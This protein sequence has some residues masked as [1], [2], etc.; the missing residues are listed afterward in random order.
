M[1]ASPEHGLAEAR[2]SE[3]SDTFRIDRRIGLEIIHGAAQAPCPGADR[4]PLV[5]GWLG[6]TRLEEHGSH[7]VGDAA[8][9]VR[10]DLAVVD[11]RDTEA[12]VEQF[13]ERKAPE[14]AAFTRRDLFVIA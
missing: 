7:T 9:E 2:Y 3:D 11:G 5:W 6:F 1:S 10:V 12:F 4:A 8:G 14:A 13:G